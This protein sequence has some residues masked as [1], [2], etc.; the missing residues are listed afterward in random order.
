[1]ALYEKSP[2]VDE[3]WQSVVDYTFDEH[4]ENQVGVYT[5]GLLKCMDAMAKGEG[6]FKDKK[7]LRRTVRIKHCQHHYIFGVIKSDAPMLVIAIFHE[8]ME[9]MKRLRKRLK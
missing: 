9:L 3:D 8:R 7:V 5:Q 6:H 1:M 4:G 2:V